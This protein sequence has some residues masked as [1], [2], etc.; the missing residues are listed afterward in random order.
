MTTVSP[1]SLALGRK[2]YAVIL[3]ACD[4]A[5]CIGA[6]LDELRTVLGSEFS[7]CV[8]VNGS[9][10]R[11][12]EIAREHGALVAQTSSRGYGY[13]CQAAID[14]LEDCGLAPEAYIF[15]AA[16]GANDPRDIPR[17]L[18]AHR[19]GVDFVLGCRT[20]VPANR[21][22][23]HGQHILANRL[24]GGWCWVLT[25]TFFKD[26][27]P[28]RLIGRE[29]FQQL[30]MQ[31]WTYG[32]T[33]EPQILA[34]RLGV[35]TLEVSVSERPRLAGKQKVSKVHWWRSLRIGVQIALAGWRSRT[36]QLERLRTI[37]PSLAVHPV[38]AGA[39]RLD[40]LGLELE[41][42]SVP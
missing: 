23:M 6:V 27:G 22:V 12:A 42:P 3:P 1:A 7:I 40:P 8:G 16:D 25:G 38:G 28:L 13:G 33:I 17:L 41:P 26:I 11:T 19:A 4:E 36:R 9:R 34:A 21:R 39:G 5:E 32:W 30:Q 37:D 29:L 2:P 35:E 24:L 15:V 31:E 18:E 10:D 20:D 14:L